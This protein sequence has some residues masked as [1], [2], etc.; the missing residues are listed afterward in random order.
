MLAFI[1]LLPS[2]RRGIARHTRLSNY[3]APVL[4]APRVVGDFQPLGKDGESVLHIRLPLGKENWNQLNREVKEKLFQKLTPVFGGPEKIY[5]AADRRFRQEFQ[6]YMPSESFLW[7]DWFQMALMLV[8]VRHYI[9]HHA[10]RRL[11]FVVEEVE[12]L[13]GFIEYIHRTGTVI[14]LQNL[15]PVYLEPFCWKML[16]EKGIAVSCGGL[17]PQ[18][19]KKDDFII[20]FQPG[21]REVVKKYPRNHLILDDFSAGLAPEVENQMLH[22]GL[23]G[24]LAAAAPLLEYYLLKNQPQICG[25]ERGMDAEFWQN[26]ISQGEKTGLWR[27]F[28]D[29]G[30]A[31]FI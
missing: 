11:I 9:Q 18:E 5:A 25:P 1:D 4:Y 23:D 3:L 29:K 26:M 19:W 17:R 2:E 8:L 7:G 14:M 31:E 10:V 20:S 30:K 28:L 22:A 16:H 15:H 12:H 21:M 27:A 24:K 13:G 6:G